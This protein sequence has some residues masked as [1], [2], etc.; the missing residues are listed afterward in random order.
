MCTY[1][2]VM[3]YICDGHICCTPT[4][5]LNETCVRFI[6]DEASYLNNVSVTN[7]SRLPNSVNS[8]NINSSCGCGSAANILLLTFFSN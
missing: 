1:M 8:R 2:L 7:T 4:H 5:V 6:T 3:L